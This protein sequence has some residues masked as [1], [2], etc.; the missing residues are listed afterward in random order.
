MSWMENLKFPDDYAV[1]FRR[2]MNLKIMNMKGLKSH[3]FHIIMERSV[4]VMFRGY[5]SDAM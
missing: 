5:V 1:G 2:S 4:L 3:N